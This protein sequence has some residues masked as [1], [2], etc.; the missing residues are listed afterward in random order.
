MS[1]KSHSC[2]VAYNP[3]LATV[4]LLVTT[5]ARSAVCFAASVQGYAPMVHKN[6]VWG[7][8]TAR[9]FNEA[10]RQLAQRQ[11]ADKIGGNKRVA[12]YTFRARHGMNNL[13]VAAVR[14][15]KRYGCGILRF[16]HAKRSE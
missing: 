6:G 9:L 12:L 2:H 5:A 1:L 16:D 7:L 15:P 13:A 10:P 8:A 4:V 3:A 11:S 14:Y